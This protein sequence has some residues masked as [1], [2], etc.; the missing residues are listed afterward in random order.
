M[1]QTI[2]LKEEPNFYALAYI[3]DNFDDLKFERDLWKPKEE[4]KADCIKYFNKREKGGKAEI[5]YKITGADSYG[6]YFVSNNSV[7]LQSLCREIRNTIC[8]NLM[9]DIDI[10]NAQPTL[11]YQYCEKKGYPSVNIKKYVLNREE[12]LTSLMNLNNIS[13]DE[14]KEEILKFLNGGKSIENLKRN[15]EIDNLLNEITTIQNKVQEDNPSLV[16]YAK[17]RKIEKYM[18]EWNIKGSVLNYLLTRL[19][20][21]A[22]QCIMNF[23][24]KKNIKI[25]SIIHDGVLIEKHF[26]KE[27]ILNDILKECEEFV[28]EKI[29]YEINILEKPMKNYFENIDSSVLNFDKK[30]IIDKDTKKYNELKNDLESFICKLEN[31]STFIVNDKRGNYHYKSEKQIID[32]YKTWNKAKDFFY[33]RHTPN[34]KPKPFIYNWVNDFDMKTYNYLDFI[35]KGEQCPSY[36]FN[37]YKGL[38]VDNDLN[39]IDVEYD[40]SKIELLIKHMKMLVDND[41]E[42]YDYFLNWIAN[43]FIEPANLSRTSIIIKTSEGLGKNYFLSFLGMLLGNNY[44]YSIADANNRCFSRFNG[45]R[46]NKLLINLDE[47][48]AKD[49]KAFYE[50]LKAEISND[51]VSIENKGLDVMEIRNFT[52]WIFTTNNELPVHISSTDRRFALFECK[53]KKPSQ[54]YFKRLGEVFKDKKCQKIF[55]MYLKKH[56]NKKINWVSDRP[57]TAFYKRSVASCKDTSFEYVSQIINNCIDN[58]EQQ[59]EY[60]LK[61]MK[62]NIRYRIECKKLYENYKKYCIN[63]RLQ[64]KPNRNF[65]NNMMEIDGVEKGYS[66][67]TAEYKLNLEK[68]KK[69]L[70]DKNLLDIV[71]EELD[72]TDDMMN[73][74]LN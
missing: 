3:I 42:S 54:E 27:L 47:A 19:E 1:S 55:Y 4:I 48:N 10:V 12:Y 24:N 69:W 7:G 21:E 8:F 15:D 20:N 16:T 34:G 74:I 49:T 45:A 9:Y 26:F 68:I 17:K 46:A 29:S 56:Y 30:D 62:D 28:K 43:I 64:T 61:K 13:R 41:K 11:L 51:T 40:E 44:Y 2:T 59:E 65:I 53:A 38:Y 71:D 22:I 14:A 70:T 18:K 63:A 66:S 6:R 72:E 57:K 32:T 60:G 37:T 67:K 25:T 33:D 58:A 31:P 23:F 73:D 5:K 52:R 35:P 50:I 36:V 39:N